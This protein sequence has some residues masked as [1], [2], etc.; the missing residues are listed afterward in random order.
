MAK[1]QA[2]DKRLED[3]KEAPDWN[4][5]YIDKDTVLTLELKVCRAKFLRDTEAIGEMD[6]FALIEYAGLKY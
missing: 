4:Q 6:P 2:K 1:V 3:Y 5:F